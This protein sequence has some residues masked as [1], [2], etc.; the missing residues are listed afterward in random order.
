MSRSML[1]EST[2]AHIVDAF[3]ALD[4]DGVALLRVLRKSLPGVSL[5]FVTGGVA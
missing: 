5:G 1:P 3:V 2:W 4:D